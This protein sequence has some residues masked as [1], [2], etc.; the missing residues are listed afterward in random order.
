MPFSP[1]W[2]LMTEPGVGVPRWVF[3]LHFELLK[4]QKWLVRGVSA[5]PA[6]AAAFCRV[7]G[8]HGAVRGGASGGASPGSPSPPAGPLQPQLNVGKHCFR[9]TQMQGALL[10][11]RYTLGLRRRAWRS[12][13]WVRQAQAACHWQRRPHGCWG[14]W[15]WWPSIPGTSTVRRRRG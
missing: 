6:V 11:A 4:L 15:R 12:L 14:A 9:F 1:A 10:G 2:L 3:Q 7:E 13:G 5:P 8:G